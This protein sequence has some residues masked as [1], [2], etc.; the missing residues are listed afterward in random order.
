M[1]RQK[2]EVAG[3]GKISTFV[4]IKNNSP[5][6][7]KRGWFIP[8]LIVAINSVAIIVRWS[9]LPELLPSHYDLQGTPSGSMSRNVLLLYPL[10]SAAICLVA[11]AIARKK[12]RLQTGLAI[13]ASG[14]C[15]VILFSSM[16]TLTSGTTPIF[17]LA[18]PVVL[19]A[20]V[21]GFVVSAVKSH[22]NKR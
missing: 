7:N 19:L 20:A 12:Y 14:I 10:A 4:I 11:Y 13:L 21:A 18:E 6:M 9:S 16:V 17:M 2:S 8:V 15:L 3:D 1:G 5:N 22:K